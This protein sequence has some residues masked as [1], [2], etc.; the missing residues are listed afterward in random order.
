MLSGI[1]WAWPRLILPCCLNLWKKLSHPSACWPSSG[2]LPWVPQISP[3]SIL[4]SWEVQGI[5]TRSETARLV[6]RNGTG[7]E[8]AET[9]KHLSKKAE[10]EHVCLETW[11]RKT[12]KRITAE[13][14][15]AAWWMRKEAWHK[16][17]VTMAELKALQVLPDPCNQLGWA[18]FPA[19]NFNF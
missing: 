7:R 14:C 19:L 5:P 1:F 18:F 16:G 8:R 10:R 12:Q 6:R 9:V 2:F 15:G 13:K 4:C 17:A 11:W 3:L